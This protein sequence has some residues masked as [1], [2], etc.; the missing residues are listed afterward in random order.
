M[1]LFLHEYRHY[2]DGSAYDNGWWEIKGNLLVN[3]VGGHHSYVPREDDEIREC[4]WEDIIREIVQDD[5]QITGWISPDGKF[6][7]CRPTDHM[8]LAEY[9]IGHDERT[10][11]KMGYVKIFEHSRYLRRDIP[12]LPKFDFLRTDGKNI[13]EGQRRI[14]EEKGFKVD[15]DEW[16]D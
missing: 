8:E 12:G 3:R 4:E 13:S 1:A 5:T 2:Q 14:L 6:Y 10:L 15:E 9:V 16:F 7:G 11:E